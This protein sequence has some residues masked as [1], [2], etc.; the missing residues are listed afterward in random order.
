LK[1]V[2]LHNSQQD[3]L[4]RVVLRGSALDDA[5]DDGHID[6][7]EPPSQRVNQQLFGNRPGEHLGP[8]QQRFAQRE[9]AIDLSSIGQ[10]AGRIDRQPFLGDVAPLADGVEVLQRKA[11]GIDVAV[12]GRARRAGAVPLE[13]LPNR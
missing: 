5:P 8:G 11:N 2:A 3:C 9:W 10:D 13:L 12:A 7:L 1:R 4:H 6:R